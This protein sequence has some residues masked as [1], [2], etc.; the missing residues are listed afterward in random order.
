M[1]MATNRRTIRQFGLGMLAAASLALLLSGPTP[2]AADDRPTVYVIAP[3]LTDPF[4]ITEQNGAKQAGADFGVNV[5]FQATPQD[6]GDA[7]MV[8]LIQA[9]IAAK[10]VGIAIDYVSKTM[11]APTTSALNAGIPVVLYNNN[12]FEGENAPA[13]ARISKLAFVGQNE[14]VSGE[15]LAKAWM[16]S[17]P[18]TPCKVL[19]VNPFPTAFV[20][21]LRA[22][23]VKRVLD[24]AHYPHTD[25]LAT[26]D[27]GQNISLIS[28]AL[29]ADKGICGIV[30]LGNPAA[31]PAAQYVGENGLK[32]PVATFDVGA[33]AAKRIK[34]GTLTMAINQQP[35]L[36][37]Y[38]TVANLANQAKYSLSPVDVNTGTSIVTAKNIDT[39]IACIQAGR[40]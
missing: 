14:S 20:L 2:A 19:I 13:D 33:E 7:G 32:I 5:V 34:D 24:A 28:A 35:F 4:W 23:G 9:A 36:Q 38:F 15:I 12:R 22:D 26:G 37:S 25:L 1:L 3:S 6:T 21:T 10:P 18:T 17:L 39:I 40:C 29:Q 16:P 8:P 11:E 31:N 27:E 30:G